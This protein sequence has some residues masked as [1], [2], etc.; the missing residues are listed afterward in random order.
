MIKRQARPDPTG[1]FPSTFTAVLAASLPP[2]SP[3]LNPEMVSRHILAS[4]NTFLD[5]EVQRYLKDYAVTDWRCNVQTVSVMTQSTDTPFIYGPTDRPPNYQHI[6]MCFG[7][8]SCG[9]LFYNRVHSDH[10][11]PSNE[12]MSLVFRSNA[13]RLGAKV[14]MPPLTRDSETE[15]SS[16]P[17]KSFETFSP[18]NDQV[19]V[20]TAGSYR[21]TILYVEDFFTRAKDLH[22]AH[23]D[24]K[25]SFLIEYLKFEMYCLLFDFCSFATP[26][27]LVST[28]PA[29]FSRMPS[30]QFPSLSQAHIFLFGPPA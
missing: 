9:N 22:A 4:K 30:T 15:V 2:S 7:W 18:Y 16:Y 8:Q 24:R 5:R 26:Y 27:T 13:V 25:D 11:N 10:H 17:P 23:I 19:H 28:A 14:V 29:A 3:T 21:S 20:G 1:S 6:F 12:F